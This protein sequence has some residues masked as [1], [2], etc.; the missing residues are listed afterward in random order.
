MT[1]GE[2][3]EETVR[4][5]V[6]DRF[7][8]PA[9]VARKLWFDWMWEKIMN[10]RILVAVCVL[11]AVISAVAFGLAWASLTRQQDMIAAWQEQQKM[12]ERLLAESQKTQA[13]SEWNPVEL[14]FVKGKEDGPAAIGIKVSMSIQAKDTGIPPM[15]AV[16]DER[17]IVRFERVRYGTYEV[18]IKNTVNEFVLLNLAVQPGQSLTRTF[19]CPGT[20]PAPTKVTVHIAWPTELAKEPIWCRFRQNAVCRPVTGTTWLFSHHMVESN[21]GQL[22]ISPN[23]EVMTGDNLERPYER[24]QSMPKGPYRLSTAYI[25]MGEGNSRRADIENASS[26]IEWPGDDYRITDMEVL[27]PHEKLF[28]VIALAKQ[29]PSQID[30]GAYGRSSITRQRALIRHFNGITLKSGDWSY[31][32]EPGKDDNPGTLWLTPTA[33]AIEKVRAALAEIEQA[34]QTAEKA[35]AELEEKQRPAAEV[36]TKEAGEESKSAAED[37]EKKE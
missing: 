3:S 25:Y 35:R 2:Q 17:G 30:R 18:W 5:R 26:T 1:G 7:G 22:M 14:R 20:P 11:M 6:L 31:R 28:S 24:G 16:S 36:Q 21:S 27:V 10:Q 19:V 23:G 32:I 33:D 9:A 15:E 37:V 8:D 13:P 34:R 29:T 12:F 4:N